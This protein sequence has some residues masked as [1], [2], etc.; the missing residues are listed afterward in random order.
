MQARILAFV[1]ALRERGIDVSIAETLD[2]V[3]GVAAAGVE[4]EVLR[5]TLAATLVKDEGDRPAFDALFEKAFPLGGA[6][7]PAGRRRRRRGG[8]PGGAEPR[9][10][11][12]GRDGGTGGTPGDEPEADARAAA[13]PLPAPLR[14]AP[15]RA[16][17]A[18]LDAGARRQARRRILAL[19]FREYTALDL[20]DAHDV[21]RELAARLRG[22]L[23]RRAG[24]ARRGRLDFRRTIR[25][26]VTTG[27]VPARLRFRAPRP[28]RP[29]LVV[30]CD[31]SRS[32]ADASGFLLALLAPL[33]RFFGRVDLYGFVD[34]P[35]P[36]ALVDGH[37][38]PDG[39]LDLHAR[40]DFGRVLVE[41]RERVRPRLGRSTLVLV[42]GDARNNRRPPRA[43]L[44]RAMR[45]RVQRVVWL[46]PEP[47]ARWDTGDSVLSLYAPACDLVLE[48]VSLGE[49][50]RA[51][52]RTF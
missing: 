3:A 41:L 13:R 12:R 45:D 6:D 39:P 1:A 40:S 44:L 18:A 27:G 7:A 30:L 43:D 48:C 21:A 8:E 28:A 37:V 16:T 4:R 42:L 22:R 34:R 25:A 50:V 24:G 20:E 51:L 23:S 17:P 31:L 15:R 5:E 2:A 11:R 46:V 32:V 52:R 36:I 9:P 19:P 14:G 10:G 35:V 29:D 47:R 49:L 26:A 33:G 38:V